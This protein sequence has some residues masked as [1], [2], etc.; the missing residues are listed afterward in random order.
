MGESSQ[1]P[2]PD[3]ETKP[4]SRLTLYVASTVGVLIIG[5]ILF[6]TWRANPGE[7]A[8]DS[9]GKVRV[10]DPVGTSQSVARVGDYQISESQLVAELK[11]RHGIEVLDKIINRTII[12]QAC[13][14]RNLEV[15]KA[16]VEREIQTIATRFSLDAPSWYKMIQSERGLSSVQY[17]RDVIWPMLALRKLAGTSLKITEADIQKEWVRSYTPRA[18]VQMILLDGTLKRASEIWEKVRRAPQDF[19]RHVTEYS[20]DPNSRPVEGRIP[21]IPRYSGNPELE[22]AAFALKPGQISSIIQVPI[23]GANR[24]VILKGDGRT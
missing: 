5:G 9:S 21:P 3:T 8:S 2:T 4:K 15:S 20:I 13:Q 23:E 18:K 1:N 6:Q 14:Q 12:Q 11:E 22:K 7:A 24:Y 17:Q 16:E 19:G 10:A